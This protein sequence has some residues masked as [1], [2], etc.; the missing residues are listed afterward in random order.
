M[1]LEPITR[2]EMFMSKAAGHG[3][4]D[5]EPVTREEMF[6]SKIEEAVKSG[7]ATPDAIK[8]AVN[9]YLDE[10]P[11]SVEEKDPTVPAWAK[12]PEKPK[13]TAEEVG[14]LPADTV[15]P[16]A[17]EIPS[18]LPNPHKLTLTGA[19]NATYDG[20]EAVSVE[21]PSGGSSGSA[22]GEMVLVRTITIEENVA[23]VTITTDDDGNT[24]ETDAMLLHIRPYATNKNSDNGKAYLYFYDEDGKRSFGFAT[25]GS[26]YCNTTSETDTA[27]YKAERI[28]VALDRGMVSAY[29]SWAT[30]S[31]NA[32]NVFEPDNT[33]SAVNKDIKKMTGVQMSNNWSN[34]VLGIGTKIEVYIRK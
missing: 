18:A 8:D 17:P 9:A 33:A 14:A 2:K 23:T 3:T 32:T 34:R 28:V 15:I 12:Q 16:E 19:V 13:Y 4:A 5:L 29:D 1:A 7:G 25:N 24:F 30:G 22:D 27:D 6:L 31:A 10:N 20:S 11:I 26:I 21:I